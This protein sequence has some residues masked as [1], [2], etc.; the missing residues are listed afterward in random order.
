MLNP[1]LINQKWASMERTSMLESV[2]VS[3]HKKR[4]VYD[5][6]VICL[7]F[8]KIYFS[9]ALFSYNGLKK[10]VHEEKVVKFMY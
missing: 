2:R 5:V 6:Y 7:L 10:H 1:K 9:V 4:S 8:M 3:L